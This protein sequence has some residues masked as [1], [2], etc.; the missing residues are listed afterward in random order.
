MVWHS[1]T[2]I[3]IRSQ[4]LLALFLLGGL[5]RRG[6]CAPLKMFL[7]MFLKGENVMDSE[8]NNN[9]KIGCQTS[10]LGIV[11]FCLIIFPMM[12]VC[13][14]AIPLRFVSPGIVKNEVAMNPSFIKMVYNEHTEELII[15]GKNKKSEFKLHKEDWERLESALTKR[16]KKDWTGWTFEEKK[17]VIGGKDYAEE[18]IIYTGTRELKEK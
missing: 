12:V 13:F 14:I 17:R 4:P 9:E 3:T 10:W 16:E 11:L 5:V 8:K 18:Y 1:K 15:T 2:R 7:L 6:Y